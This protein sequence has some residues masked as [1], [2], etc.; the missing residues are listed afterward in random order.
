MPVRGQTG[1]WINKGGDSGQYNVKAY[2]AVGDGVTDDTLSIQAAID[3][4]YAGGGTVFLPAGTYIVSSTIGITL[5]ADVILP[6]PSIIGVQSSSVSQY[7]ITNYNGALRGSI[8]KYTGSGTCLKF[9]GTNTTRC[10][11][12]GVIRDIT[13]MNNHNGW[14]NDATIGLD[15]TFCTEHRLYN[16]SLLGFNTGFYVY[17]SWSSD[18]FGL[19]AIHCVY[20]IK[21]YSNFNAYGLFGTQLH[22]NTYGIVIRSG[23]GSTIK[24]TTIE[25]CTVGIVIDYQAGDP[26]PIPSKITLEDIYSELSTTADMIIGASTSKVTSADIIHD[27]YIKNYTSS[28]T[29]TNFIYIDKAASVIVNDNL[30]GQA[31]S[32]V[33]TTNTSQVKVLSNT[34]RYISTMRTQYYSE[35][36]ELQ[37]EYPYNLID[38]GY[39][40]LPSI[41]QNWIH[42]YN[43]HSQAGYGTVSPGVFEWA[44]VDD[45]DVWKIMINNPHIVSNFVHYRIYLTDKLYN[46]R[47]VAS[48]YA[49][50]DSDCTVALFIYND[51]GNPIQAGAN[52]IG[53]SWGVTSVWATIPATGT[54]IDIAFTITNSSGLTKYFYVATMTATL[55]GQ[56][57]LYRSPMDYIKGLSGITKC[58]V[59]GTVI[60]LDARFLTGRYGVLV[61]PQGNGTAYVVTGDSQFTIYTSVDNL[62]CSWFVI[63]RAGV[64]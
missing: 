18:C 56:G 35:N 57:Q 8:I 37:I 21:A 20:G 15:L 19:T 62:P 25:N 14:P 22:Q 30:R 39:T 51:H 17:N 31:D 55:D 6:F 26:A 45:M 46:R 27:I 59:A 9:A 54:Y 48:C 2:G 28:G 42:P 3:A 47:I 44:T 34:D 12:G 58:A 10:F 61:T 60:T 41:Q 23:I 29:P 63:P 1:I 36:N 24:R 52:A 13:I 16:V 4:A 38:N 53:E 64:F 40:R 11:T 33:T 50:R 43:P 5:S 7:A 32:I 49:K